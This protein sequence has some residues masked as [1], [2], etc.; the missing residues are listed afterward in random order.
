MRLVWIAMIVAAVLAA[1]AGRLSGAAS[2]W[3]FFAAGGLMLGGIIVAHAYVS[4]SNHDGR[5]SKTEGALLL[6]RIGLRTTAARSIAA[7]VFVVAVPVVIFLSHFL[8][9]S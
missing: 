1:M 7:A 2:Q 9:S 3:M 8:R 6:R 5:R 4:W